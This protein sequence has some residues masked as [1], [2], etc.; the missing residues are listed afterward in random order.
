LGKGAGRAGWGPP[1]ANM[2]YLTSLGYG[3]IAEEGS[4]GLRASRHPR[5]DHSPP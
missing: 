2:T 1:A 3:V 5:I 4:G